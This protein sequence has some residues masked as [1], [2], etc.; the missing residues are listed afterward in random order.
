MRAVTKTRMKNG[1]TKKI[2]IGV[3]GT[4]I[5]KILEM[6]KKKAR[7]GIHG[8]AVTKVQDDTGQIGPRIGPGSTENLNTRTKD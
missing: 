2:T 1:V 5:K 8:P 4:K 6:G 7:T 3:I